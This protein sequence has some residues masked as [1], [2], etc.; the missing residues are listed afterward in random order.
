MCQ[1]ISVYQNS[2]YF[3][4]FIILFY[5]LG[6]HTCKQWKINIYTPH[7]SLPTPP[8]SS[9]HVP[10]QTSLAL[11]F[12]VALEVINTTTTLL[13]VTHC[14]CMVRS[15]YSLRRQRQEFTEGRDTDLRHT[16][17]Y[18]TPPVI[19]SWDR[20]IAWVF[21]STVSMGNIS[22][23]WLVRKKMKKRKEREREGRKV[24]GSKGRRLEWRN[25]PP[26]SAED[27]FPLFLLQNRNHGTLFC[28]WHFTLPD[29]WDE[30]ISHLFLRS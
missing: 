6:F 15:Y 20:G 13:V 19:G 27:S 28:I 22:R 23:T 1:L 2:E 30:N 14:N 11:W 8:I 26:V 25:F 18:H 12:K 16:C 7:F 10:I 24:R 5:S 21:Q 9:Q 4:V 17:W 3:C 29:L